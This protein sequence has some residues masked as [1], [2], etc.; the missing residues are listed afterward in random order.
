MAGRAHDRG[1][2]VVGFR[3]DEEAVVRDELA[4]GWS[5]HLNFAGGADGAI[6]VIGAAAS[7]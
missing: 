1:L 6:P 4:G 3:A 7:Q 5:G 2:V